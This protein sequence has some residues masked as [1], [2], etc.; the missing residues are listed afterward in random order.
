MAEAGLLAHLN[1]VLLH[2][3]PWGLG[4]GVV[5]FLLPLRGPGRCTLSLGLG[6][7]LGLALMALSIWFAHHAGRDLG[8]WQVVGSLSLIGGGLMAVAVG[9]RFLL[10]PATCAA[11]QDEQAIDFECW[12]MAQVMVWALA[13][14]VLVRLVSL[15]PDLLLRPVFPWDAWK[16]WAWKARVWFEAGELVQFAPYATWQTAGADE[17][18]MEG[19]HHPDLVSLVMLWSAIAIG[20]WDDSLVGIAWLMAGLSAGLMVFG[21]L[22]HLGSPVAMAWLGVYLLISAPMVATHIALFGYADLWVMLYFLVFTTG[23]VF[24]VRHRSWWPLVV[25][26]FGFVMMALA[27]DTG[28]YWLP[29]LALGWL[30]VTLSNRVLLVLLAAGGVL[31]VGFAVL[32]FDPLAWLSSGRYGLDPREPVAALQGMGR[33]LFIWLD[34]HLT[35]YLMPAVV[36][37]ALMRSGQMPELRA[38][39]VVSL[40]S[41]AV[42]MGGFL[43]TRAA[44]YAAVGTLF[45]RILLQIYPV[46]VLMSVLALWCWLR[47]RIGGE[48]GAAHAIP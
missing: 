4:T 32:G 47:D 36:A 44:E 34:W 24:W 14:L 48:K 22:R 5:G 12:S 27:K 26:G 39:L 31:A 6:A 18:V 40:V 46:I 9:L 35:W 20:A 2:L 15:L 42:A 10:R 25:M 7:A 45:S 28:I 33:H 43:V 38:L 1:L 11:I 41:L 8:V 16:L 29:V 23:L 13:A 37:L 3:L 21:M 17:F 30:A 19:V